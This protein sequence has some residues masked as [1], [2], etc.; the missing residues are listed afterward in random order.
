MKSAFL[1]I[2]IIFL[3]GLVLIAYIGYNNPSLIPHELLDLLRI[4]RDSGQDINKSTQR[5]VGIDIGP[6]VY[7]SNFIIEE[8]VTGLRQPTTMTFVGNDILILEK[9]TGFVKLIRDDK[10]I[11]DPIYDFEV[12]YSNESGLLGIES[13]DNDV[14]IFVTESEKDGG[15]PIGNNIYHFIWN[16]NT[17]VDKK[18]LT[19]LSSESSWHNGGALAVGL[20]GQVYAVIGDQMGGDRENLKNDF[21]I[22]Q[23]VNNGEIDDSG[24]I[25]KVGYENNIISPKSSDTPLDHYRAIGIRNSF[26]LTIDPSNGNLWDTENGPTSFDEINLVTE[27][28]NSG[29]SVIMGPASKEQIAQLPK[30]TN[31]E[32]SEPE[33]SWEQPVSPTG[34][35]FV[36]SDLFNSYENHLFVGT[37]SAG[38]ILKFKLNDNRTQFE[39]STPHLQDLVVNTIISDSEKQQVESIEE[40]LFGDGFGC[41]TD[42]EFGPDG[43]LYVI[44]LS[45]NILYKIN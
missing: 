34:L 35:E 11:E 28:F 29:W 10:L 12:V 38:Q 24:I 32:Y 44:S 36:D 4:V 14:Y 3:V 31:F 17:L 6:K 43:S 37:C 19:T 39:F 26:G 42:I 5:S 2:L 18:L 21:R 22:L 25:V 30:L 27:N 40:I 23:N 45:D 15:S 9:N 1:F 33:F 8:F 41:I 16:G 13:N 20:N 7:D